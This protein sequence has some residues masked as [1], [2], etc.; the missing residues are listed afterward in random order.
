MFE[1]PHLFQIRSCC[2]AA[3]AAVAAA[4]A[5][6]AAHDND[7]D[8]NDDD[9]DDDD[10]GDATIRLCLRF[11]TLVARASPDRPNPPPTA[12]HYDVMS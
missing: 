9:D 1:S 4:A 12:P 11:P 6:A 3:A 10:D 2:A 5:A 8:D 7:D